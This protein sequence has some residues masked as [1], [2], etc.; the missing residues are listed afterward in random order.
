MFA[1]RPMFAAGKV[2]PQL[3]CQGVTYGV[4]NSDCTAGILLQILPNGTWEVFSADT[5]S[6]TPINS[7][8]SGIWHDGGG[9][10]GVYVRFTRTASTGDG[11]APST[12]WL[13]M[14]TTRSVDCVSGAQPGGSDSDSGTYTIEFATDSGGANIISTT[15]GVKLNTVTT[16]PPDM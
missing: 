1:V 8:T 7:P 14:N 16:C 4:G 15:T 13:Q 12:G 11:S 5:I 9:D 2:L 10:A 6:T 3:T